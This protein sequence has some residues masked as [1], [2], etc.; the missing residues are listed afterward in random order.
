MDF[1]HVRSLLN[2]AWAAD[3][4]L[5]AAFRTY[6]GGGGPDDADFFVAWL[7]ERHADAARTRLMDSGSTV[8]IGA[9]LPPRLAAALDD[10]ATLP[11]SGTAS[12]AETMQGAAVATPSPKPE[13]EFHYELL[14]EAGSGGMGTVYVAK[15]NELL[16]RVA[17]KTL[18]QPT[19]GSSEGQARF[20]R[21]AQI[22]AQLNHPNIVP[23]HALEV[24]PDGS[25]AYT[26]KLVEGR[27]LQAVIEETREQYETLGRPDEAHALP[28]R[29]EHFLKVCDAMAYA[30]H[31]G[32]IHRDLKPANLML[33]RYNE[34]YVMDWGLCRLLGQPQSSAAPADVSRVAAPAQIS[35][36][37]SETQIGDVIGTP[38][39]MS[40]EQAQGRNADLDARS[41]QYALGLV[42][43][44]LATLRAPYAGDSAYE[45]LVNASMGRR[46]PV[47]PVFRG[48]RL[49]AELIAVIE[50]ATAPAPGE[51]YANVADFAADLRRCLRDEAV[52][53]RP[54]SLWR[55]LLR[56]AVRHRLSIAMSILTL[57]ALGSAAIGGLI[58]QNSR[59][60][61]AAHALE[62]RHQ[63]LRNAV[64]RIGDRVQTRFIQFQGDVENLA[65]S[66]A[67]FVELG[68][69]AGERYYW[70]SDF[71]NEKTAPPDLR[72][73]PSV[74]G[75]LSLSVPVWSAPPGRTEASLAAEVERVAP[76]Q[77]FVR[78]MYRRSA[79]RVSRQPDD[80]AKDVPLD[81]STM[82]L[83]ELSLG[84]EDGLGFC[85]PG[86]DG[87]PANYDPRE[88]AW[89][90]LAANKTGPQWGVPYVSPIFGLD[91][92]PLS[93][94]M[95]ARDGHFLGV[96]SAL[97]LPDRVVSSVLR[98]DEVPGVVAIL[99]VDGEGRI[100]VQT[101]GATSGTNAAS[102]QLEQSLV[103]EHIRTHSE[104]VIEAPFRG[105]PRTIAFDSVNPLGWTVVAVVDTDA[106][107]TLVVPEL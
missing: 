81:A 61:A 36:G 83:A 20:L 14:G 30:H 96:V 102:H 94:P 43:Y 49:G 93:V 32:V 62:N 76:L 45:V 99:L 25:P 28:A 19:H 2:P 71:Q 13:R 75:R 58:W 56:N 78:D 64:A 5:E 57:F 21:E 34:V 59:S 16:R 95:H 23:V 48:Q 70:R 12:A 26:M 79:R 40:P 104:G 9:G 85:F 98:I 97:L 65:D 74:P 29:L 50:H 82:P 15:D 3:I 86:W 35:G 10:N 60:L 80:S 39:Y 18:K 24:T 73:F 87:L 67:Q 41:D 22:T 72:A 27:T 63:L 69:P 31:K 4:D 47:K 89:Y 46:R 17:L 88:R 107:D 51:R 53:A 106:L 103:L 6:R 66:I 55:S 90:T 84:L 105:V 92:L 101:G 33:G 44:E 54:D 100:L 37:A 7:G 77:P 38:K 11:M 8:Q 1:Q 42:L 91:I 52:V 68:R